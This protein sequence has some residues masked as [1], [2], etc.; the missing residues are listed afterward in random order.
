MAD[1]RQIELHSD[2]LTGFLIWMEKGCLGLR[3]WEGYPREHPPRNH[4]CC[5][6]YD[7]FGLSRRHLPSISGLD[8]DDDD[9]D[10]DGDDVAAGVDVVVRR[11]PH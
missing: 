5:S 3:L 11:H 8:G 10:G 7:M 9:D 2:M 1:E 4:H 6:L